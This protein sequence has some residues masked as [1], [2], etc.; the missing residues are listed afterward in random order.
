MCLLLLPAY[1]SNEFTSCDTKNSHVSNQKLIVE[2]RSLYRGQKEE[3]EDRITLTLDL[4]SGENS[5][6]NHLTR[7]ETGE[8]AERR[9]YAR[10]ATR[11]AA[12]AAAAAAILITSRNVTRAAAAP[13]HSRYIR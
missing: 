1:P 2:F 3:D 5:D 8:R 4:Q 12:A 6:A 11:A 7:D 9:R 13:R 10:D